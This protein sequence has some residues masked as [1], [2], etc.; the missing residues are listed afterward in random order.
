M[1]E[2]ERGGE[3][4]KVGKKMERKIRELDRRREM[5]ERKKRRKNVL[6]KGVDIR[7]GGMEKVVGRIWK[8]I[9]AQA[10]IDE[11]RKIGKWNEGEDNDS[12]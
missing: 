2:R 4:D 11:A 6:L 12:N 10:E 3:I 7:E 9:G 1:W 8:V 5:E